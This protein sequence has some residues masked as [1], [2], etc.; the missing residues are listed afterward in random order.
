METKRKKTKQ[1]Q[2]EQQQWRRQRQWRH[3]TGL[4]HQHWMSVFYADKCLFD[5]C[6]EWFLVLYGQPFNMFRGC[7][8]RITAEMSYRF[9]YL[10]S[11]EK[12]E[13]NWF[14]FSND[15]LFAS[16]SLFC[17]VCVVFVWFRKVSVLTDECRLW[18]PKKPVRASIGK[19]TNWARATFILEE[20]SIWPNSI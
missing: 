8:G 17:F 3:S 5:A 1:Q 6:V 14:F 19:H 16:S 4:G 15:F 13:P 18:K 2:Q 12:I 10:H 11:Q 9:D 20:A 7:A